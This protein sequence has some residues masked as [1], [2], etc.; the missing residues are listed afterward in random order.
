[1]PREIPLTEFQKGQAI[2]YK[3]NGKTI[4][5]IAG[6]LNIGKREIAEF[7]NK[8]NAHKKGEKPGRHQKVT[9]KSQRNSL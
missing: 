5:E 9:P 7:L 1:M 6:I 2:I 3:N 4:R 8:P